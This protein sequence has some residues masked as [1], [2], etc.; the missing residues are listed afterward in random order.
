[1]R[2]NWRT[3]S[4]LIR[5]V[6]YFTYTYTESYPND[7]HVASKLHQSTCGL[8][9]FASNNKKKCYFHFQLVIR[10]L[11]P[12]Q[13]SPVQITQ[14]ATLKAP[15]LQ[16]RPAWGHKR[17]LQWLRFLANVRYIKRN[18]AAE[19]A[20]RSLNQ[21]GTVEGVWLLDQQHAVPTRILC[22]ISCRSHLVSFT[23]SESSRPLF[24]RGFSTSKDTVSQAYFAPHKTLHKK[25]LV[26]RLPLRRF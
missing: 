1:M 22:P 2:Y 14:D 21:T 19:V 25:I 26:L 7:W 9:G 4:I 17:Q 20:S 13:V 8:C 15:F 3:D 18:A 16:Q 6:E 24:Q 10:R 11:L 5:N 12:P 23:R